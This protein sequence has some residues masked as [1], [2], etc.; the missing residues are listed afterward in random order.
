MVRTMNFERYSKAE[1]DQQYI[2]G[3]R[4]VFKKQAVFCDMTED[5]V[6]P[7][8]PALYGEVTLR[9]RTAH[10]NVD[11]VFLMANDKRYLMNKDVQVGEFDYYA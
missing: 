5:Y 4:P 6:R 10:N 2:S 8:Q 7:A 1:R 9:I 11:K 3:M